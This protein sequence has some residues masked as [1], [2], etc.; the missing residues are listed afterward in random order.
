[1]VTPWLSSMYH[2]WG[3]AGQQIL[4]R[5]SCL[6]LP[7]PWPQVTFRKDPWNGRLPA[8]SRCNPLFHNQQVIFL[9]QNRICRFN[10]PGRPYL[11]S[12][13]KAMSKDFSTCGGKTSKVCHHLPTFQLILDRSLLENLDSNH[14]TFLPFPAD[15]NTS[16]SDRLLCLD[17]S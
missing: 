8:T 4:P 16:D 14:I 7:I 11:P 10:H 6:F 5:L 3:P 12:G 1:M 17:S 15:Q 2:H 13:S 9:N